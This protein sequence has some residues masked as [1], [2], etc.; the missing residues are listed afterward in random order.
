MNVIYFVK[1]HKLMNFDLY[2]HNTDLS[3]YN[4]LSY[5][6]DFYSIDIFVHF[7]TLD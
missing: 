2:S 6:R 4:S 7:W 5:L 3:S 1:F